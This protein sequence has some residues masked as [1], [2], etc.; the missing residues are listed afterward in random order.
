M[1]DKKNQIILKDLN[2]NVGSKLFFKNL[3]LS[4]TTS[5]ITV[6][7]GPNGSGKSLLTKIIKGIVKPDSGCLSIYLDGNHPESGYLSQKITFFRRNIYNNLAY[8]M[9]IRGYSNNEISLRINYLLNKFEFKGKEKESARLLSEGN[10]QYLSFIRS[11]V[12]N[13]KLLIL[14]EPSSN[15][16]MKFTKK[17]ED[18]LIAAKTKKKVIMVTHDIFQARRL[19]DEILLL[20]DGKIVEISEKKIFLKS[21]NKLVRKFLKGNLF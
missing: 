12:N 13:P 9:K 20:N 21:T 19:A 16:D 8:P 6:I 17:I 5:G 14:D 4:F 10:K 18:Y 2:F 1:I 11:L 15:L 3:C 7:L